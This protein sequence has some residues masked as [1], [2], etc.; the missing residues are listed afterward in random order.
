MFVLCWTPTEKDDD[1]GISYTS[2]EKESNEDAKNSSFTVYRTATPEKKPHQTVEEKVTAWRRKW[3]F[4][5]FVPPYFSPS[6]FYSPHA[7]TLEPM[8]EIRVIFDRNDEIMSAVTCDCRCDAGA[9]EKR[10]FLSYK[11]L[12]C[13]TMTSVHV[14]LGTCLAHILEA[15]MIVSTLAP[16]D[17]VLK[18]NEQ[19]EEDDEYIPYWLQP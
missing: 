3:N 14:E 19:D 2:N 15:N 10:M 9:L 5:D 17:E 11:L 18:Y 4:N 12:N 1:E 6:L 8:D 13:S 16:V 7:F